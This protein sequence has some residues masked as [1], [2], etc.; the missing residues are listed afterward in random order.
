MPRKEGAPMMGKVPVKKL[1]EI[2][3][4]LPRAKVRTRS[5]SKTVD[6]E[7]VKELLLL[8]AE[9]WIKRL[10][11]NQNLQLLREKVKWQEN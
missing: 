11:G 6:M 8:V 7:I 3:K 2:G 9:K 10:K 1:V 4:S 5:R